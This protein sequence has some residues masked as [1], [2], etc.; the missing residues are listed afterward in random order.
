MPLAAGTRLGPYEIVASLGAGGMGEVYRARDMRLGRAVAVKV[1]PQE[2]ATTDR[3]QRFEQEARA[4]AA[5]NH[6]N[7]L[8]LYDVGKDADTPFLVTELLEGRTLARV[9]AE[10]RPSIARTLDW[11]TQAAAGLAAAHA[12]GIVHRDVKPDNLFVTADS[13]LKILDFGLVKSL[14]HDAEGETQLGTA[15]HTV[16]G[17]PRYMAPEQV[18]GEAVDHRADLFAFGAVLYEMVSGRPAFPGQS[19][20][21]ILASILRDSPPPLVSTSDQPITP[22][23]AQ[24]VERCLEKSRAARFQ[25]TTD[26]EFALKMLPSGS[27]SD[28]TGATRVQGIQSGRT[29][30]SAPRSSARWWKTVAA[31]IVLIALGAMAGYWFGGGRELRT[32]DRTT[33]L[34]LQIPLRPPLLWAPRRDPTR[35]GGIP[36]DR[37]MAISSDGRQIVFAAVEFSSGV[38]RLYVRDFT[39]VEPRPLENTDN[40]R[41]PFFSPDGNRIGFFTGGRL[42]WIATSGGAAHDIC[43]ASSPAGG[44]WGEDD[45]IIFAPEEA[46]G[47]FRVSV[48]DTKPQQLTTPASNIS[49]ASDRFPHILPGATAVLYQTSSSSGWQIVVQALPAGQPIP[50]VEGSSPQFSQGYLVYNG[51]GEV[52]A[53]PFDASRLTVGTPVPLRDRPGFDGAI[54]VA[55]NGTLIYLPSVDPPGTLVRIDRQGVE[56][57]IPA[58]RRRYRVPR[59]SGDGKRALVSIPE[60]GAV[61]VNLATGFLEILPLG[62]GASAPAWGPDERTITYRSPRS[63]AGTY[64][65]RID[66]EHSPVPLFPMTGALWLYSWSRDSRTLLFDNV[67]RDTESDTWMLRVGDP[68]GPQNPRK[69]A[70]NSTK[71]DYNQGISADGQWRAVVSGVNGQPSLYV[72]AF[73]DGALPEPAVVGGVHAHWAR[74]GNELFFRLFDEDGPEIWAVKV[75]GAGAK[76]VVGPA[77]LVQKLPD[78]QPVRNQPGAPSYDV[79]PDGSFL[80]VKEPPGPPAEAIVVVLNFVSAFV[81]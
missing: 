1:L 49:N 18:R 40:A 13:R 72:V 35:D 29:V 19:T 60:E 2:F 24:I 37:P 74:Q 65:Q 16:L 42:K 21:E 25:S 9:L 73:P 14:D 80:Y 23:L 15:P 71:A 5:L 66:G 50:L 70:G 22:G 44:A 4:V 26:L 53:R 10:E 11:A 30:S 51:Q 36:G 68:R 81:R 56:R 67:G 7:I 76:A 62:R 3:L 58:P 46:G 12:R 20:Q 38:R 55:A 69:L 39:D 47:L 8:A 75:S 61:V 41:Q 54:S 48:N 27:M 28:R 64:T 32:T 45:H 6:P 34:R 17:T 31:V 63:P 77:R 79:F 59:I 43:A 57:P 33:A 78:L 52:F